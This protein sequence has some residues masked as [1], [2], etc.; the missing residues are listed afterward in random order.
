[1]DSNK[2]QHSK[3]TRTNFVFG[4][5]PM[6]V[7][8]EKG[9][10]EGVSAIT[11]GE[12]LGHG[13]HVDAEFLDN[14]SSQGNALKTGCK[15]RFG[16]PAMSSSAMGTFLGRAKNFRRDSSNGQER[17]L[18]DVTVSDS[19]AKS[20]KGDLKTYVL[21][22]AQKDADM[23]GMSIVFDKG[24]EYQRDELGQK[25]YE[26]LDYE[27]PVFVELEKLW[28]VDM[29]DDPAANPDG[30]FDA[31]GIDINLHAATVSR[32]INEHPEVYEFARENPDII[33]DFLTR[34]DKIKPQK[35]EAAMPEQKNVQEW[36]KAYGNEFAVDNFGKMSFE[37]AATK[38]KSESD[39][40][41][42]AEKDA[43]ITAMAAEIEAMK[44]TSAAKITELE[45]GKKAAEDKAKALEAGATPVPFV[46]A[47]SKP[48][49]LPIAS[50][51]TKK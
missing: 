36:A 12:A 39:A 25:I 27:K 6:K 20:P 48:A 26:G 19:A 46:D 7:D 40:K 28:A 32:F 18:C 42:A 29:V 35:K 11:A 16:H 33:Q 14:V 10:I 49:K 23:F 44:A 24:Q 5:R 15:V 17:T 47:A 45:A 8:S 38:H 34:Y 31:T 1:M 30:L 2:K 9:I 43:K 4:F 22:M 13:F 37:E 21:T 3:L 50:L 41:L 51:F